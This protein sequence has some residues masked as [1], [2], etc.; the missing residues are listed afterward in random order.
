[1]PRFIADGLR[2]HL[3]DVLWEDIFKLSASA[4]ANEFCKWVQVRI[5]VYTPHR[6]CQV[7]S[8]SS[9]WFAAAFAS[10]IVHRNQ[11]FCLFVCLYQQNKS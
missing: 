7:Q 1:M 5:D 3:R 4:A 9:P 8:H 10:G 11:F 6:K 2:Y